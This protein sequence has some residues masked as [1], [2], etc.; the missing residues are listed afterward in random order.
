MPSAPLERLAQKANATLTLA[1]S[2]AFPLKADIERDANLQQALEDIRALSISVSY[3]FLLPRNTFYIAFIGHYSA[4]KS[5]TL[6]S[7][8]GTQR[9]SDVNPTDQRLTFISS[10]PNTRPILK[11]IE[12]ETTSV[13]EFIE[14][15]TVASDLTRNMVL[16]DTPG[17][18]DPKIDRTLIQNFLPVC[19]A[20]AYF[21]S[22]AAPFNSTDQQVLHP[23]IEELNFIPMFFIVTRADEF[24]PDKSRILTAENFD[25][26]KAEAAVQT[27]KKRLKDDFG[28]PGLESKAH[29]LID[30][31]ANFGVEELVAHIG[32]L[33]KNHVPREQKVVE[34]FQGRLD[35]G[36]TIVVAYVEKISGL[37]AELHQRMDQDVK[38]FEHQSRRPNADLE[39]LIEETAHGL[40]GQREAFAIRAPSDVD[41]NDLATPHREKD[42]G[43][44]AGRT[45]FVWETRREFLQ[46]GGFLVDQIF[47]RFSQDFERDV[48]AAMLDRNN[49]NE[50]L[51]TDLA[52]ED[53]FKQSFD[54]P[55]RLIEKEFRL[56]WGEFRQAMIDYRRSEGEFAAKSIQQRWE[57]I[58]ASLAALKETARRREVLTF[59][60]NAFRRLTDF[61]DG[62]AKDFFIL[63]QSGHADVL[64][65][66]NKVIGDSVALADV[67]ADLDD[68]GLTIDG[69]RAIREE[70]FPTIVPARDDARRAFA[71]VCDE[72]MA[73]TPPN[74]AIDASDQLSGAVAAV[75]VDGRLGSIAE[76]I[77]RDAETLARDTLQKHIA[78]AKRVEREIEEETRRISTGAQDRFDSVWGWARHAVNAGILLVVGGVAYL[79]QG[80]ISDSLLQF[81]LGGVALGVINYFVLELVARRTPTGEAWSNA[82]DQID[83]ARREMRQRFLQELRNAD[84]Q[85]YLRGR[86]AASRLASRLEG[87]ADEIAVEAAALRGPEHDRLVEALDAESRAVATIALKHQDEWR[88]FLKFCETFHGDGKWHQSRINRLADAIKLK[89]LTRRV[90]ALGERRATIDGGLAQLKK[91][92]NLR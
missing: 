11:T 49:E 8:L 91:I 5:S 81:G 27:A 42:G 69:L 59:E 75:D 6:N 23:Y 13:A 47:R 86:E 39:T 29:I 92:Q 58:R 20:I 61:A 73:A 1:N 52:F 34:H 46:R 15:Q 64:S 80:G 10:E 18:G 82:D 54:D 56:L 89:T 41:L 4:G 14:V 55:M 76:A 28:L 25:A 88:R 45:E 66:K 84:S 67:L 26:T 30:N 70:Q 71:A 36:L 44:D 19:D 43:G 51:A 53:V 40:A 63:V 87:I 83:A 38:R 33:R 21:T 79:I 90:K 3:Y 50:A 65:F 37:C 77:V 35:R 60:E 57:Q 74:G 24:R 32:E 7:L 72:V 22:G 2:T 12:T 31:I 62:A 16:I 17:G 78:A 48:V 68:L 85:H 9:E